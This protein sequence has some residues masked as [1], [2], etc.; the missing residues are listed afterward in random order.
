M[1]NMASPPDA[2]G[3]THFY[4]DSSSASNG[5]T[6]AAHTV[7]SIGDIFGAITTNFL[8]PGLLPANSS[9]VVVTN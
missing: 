2:S 3:N 5:C 6:D 4:A 8:S 1:E 9:G 7:S